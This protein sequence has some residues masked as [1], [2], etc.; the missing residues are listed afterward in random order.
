MLVNKSLCYISV[1]YIVVSLHSPTFG[2]RLI[3]CTI[4]LLKLRVLSKCLASA[5]FIPIIQPLKDWSFNKKVRGFGSKLI[6]E[7][8]T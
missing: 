5:N 8:I 1:R 7:T 4:T 3:V 2:K 6:D